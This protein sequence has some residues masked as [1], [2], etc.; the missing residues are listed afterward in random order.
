MVRVNT[1]CLF[2]TLIIYCIKIVSSNELEINQI[3]ESGCRIVTVVHDGVARVLIYPSIQ[4]PIRLIRDLNNVIWMGH[5]EESLRCLTIITF[6][7]SVKAILFIEVSNAVSIDVFFLRKHM[8][9]YKNITRK[10]C[11]LEYRCFVDI[12]KDHLEKTGEA[13]K[14]QLPFIVPEKLPK[15]KP[16]KE[17]KR[18]YPFEMDDTEEPAKKKIPTHTELEPETIPVEIESDDEEDEVD[19]LNVSRPDESDEQSEQ[20]D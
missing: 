2:Y 9:W 15:T 7:W 20:N 10:E 3:G 14:P 12:A 18:E 1:L 17:K 5:P 16:K 8:N 11:K 13:I 4:K 6:S 19:V